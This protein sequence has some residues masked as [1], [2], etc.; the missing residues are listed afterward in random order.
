EK[1]YDNKKKEIQT[2]LKQKAK[3]LKELTNP[4]VSKTNYNRDDLQREISSAKKLETEEVKKCEKILKTEDKEEID[5]YE[6]LDFNFEKLHNQVLGIINYELNEI[7]SFEEL[8][9]PNK[10]EFA[11]KGLSLHN[12]GDKCLFCGNIVENERYFKLEKYFKVDEIN[13]LRSKVNILIGE[14]DNVK[15]SIKSLQKNDEIYFE[16]LREDLSLVEEKYKSVL[17]EE[18][19]YIDNLI[20][21]LKEKCRTPYSNDIAMPNLIESQ[22]IT[23]IKEHNKIIEKHN[24]FSKNI[25][26]EQEQA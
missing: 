5:N 17:L 7:V 21:G 4:R 2:F 6:L 22:Y 8:N 1:I 10:K 25:K 3:F 15:N 16:H 24:L 20:G 19:N 9:K 12:P 18:R 14:L 11:E 26:Y 23:Y 13:D